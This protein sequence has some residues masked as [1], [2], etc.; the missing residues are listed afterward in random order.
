M[1]TDVAPAWLPDYLRAREREGR[2]LPD[3]LVA[4]LPDLPAG[5]PL[6]REWLARADSS[7]RLLTYLGTFDGPLAIVDA[8]TG[9]GWLAAA[10]AAL[11]GTD[12]IGIDVNDIELAQARRV[13]GARQ[14][15]RFEEGDLATMPPPDPADVIVLASVIQYQAD[16]GALL[17]RLRGWLADDGELHVLDSPI[18]RPEDVAAARERTRTHY[19]GIGVPEMSDAY[20]HHTW[21]DFEPL[22][23]VVLNQP[24]PSAGRLLRRLTGRVETPFPWLVIR[25]EVAP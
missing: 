19:A 15:V 7:R 2:L 16:L 11:P 5:H 24:R 14:N 23:P 8:G 10:I 13:F 9:N 17:T 21:A 25:R 12:V 3:D 4:R 22:H 6:Q 18:Y 1:P 20:H